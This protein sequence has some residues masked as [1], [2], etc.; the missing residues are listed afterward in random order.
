MLHRD[1]ESMKS[2]LVSI[3][4]ALLFV[5]CGGEQLGTYSGGG[6]SGEGGGVESGG[7]SGESGTFSEAGS[8]S[9]SSV[10]DETGSF[11]DAGSPPDAPVTQPDTGVIGMK[12]KPGPSS[13]TGGPGGSCSTSLSETCADG[14]TYE[15]EC[16]CPGAICSCSFSMGSTGGGGGGSPYAGCSSDC[17]DPNRAWEACGFP[18]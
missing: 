5:N 4:P 15:A 11:P 6:P 16:K 2:L 18:H 10:V 7:G 14:T 13:G 12:C 17:S 1:P 9:D 3:L 8:V